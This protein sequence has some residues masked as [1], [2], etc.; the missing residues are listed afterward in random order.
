[1]IKRHNHNTIAA[2][3]EG[4]S[5]VELIVVLMIVFVLLM[6]AF[7]FIQ[8]AR[9]ASRRIK[10]QTH[11]RDLGESILHFEA[12][13]RVLVKDGEKGWGHVVFLLPQLKQ[14]PLFDA[15]DPIHVELTKVDEAEP[16]TTGKAIPVLRCPTFSKPMILVGGFARG[17]AIGNR[18][19]FAEPIRT[20]EIPDGASF[21][22]AFGET[23][24][25]HAWAQPELGDYLPPNTSGIY[26]SQH[27]GGANFALCDTSVRYVANTIDKDVFRNLCTI[28]DSESEETF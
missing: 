12:E 9:E 24:S 3:R 8:S 15:L 13:N 1:M 19:V 11:F 6:L 4:F 20:E 2:A 26:G 28:S 14:K 10:C 22:F 7:P 5:M 21:T 17:N 27:P 25:D 16:S 23:I 18:D